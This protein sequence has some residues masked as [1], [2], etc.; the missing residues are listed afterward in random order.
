[1]SDQKTLVRLDSAPMLAP[2]LIRVT[3]PSVWSWYASASMK[4]STMS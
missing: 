4:A 3:V 1:M 2:S